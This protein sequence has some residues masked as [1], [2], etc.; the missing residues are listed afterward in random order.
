MSLGQPGSYEKNLKQYL[1]PVNYMTH[2]PAIKE[3]KVITK[4]RNV[5]NLAMPNANMGMSLIDCITE[6]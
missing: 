3:V 5:S 6:G 2:F 4:V 1:S